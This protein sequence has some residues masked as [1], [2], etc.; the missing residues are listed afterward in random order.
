MKIFGSETCGRELSLNENIE[1]FLSWQH[2][3]SVH[4]LSARVGQGRCKKVKLVTTDSND[5]SV[6]DIR[7]KVAELVMVVQAAARRE[8]NN[9]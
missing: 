9:Q 6:G 2:R 1:V 8:W 3:E 4:Q 7:V 5:G